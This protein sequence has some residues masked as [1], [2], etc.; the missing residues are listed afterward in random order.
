MGLPESA[1]LSAGLGVQCY[2]R[3]ATGLDWA[4]EVDPGSWT[5][6]MRQV[7][8]SSPRVLA[9]DNRSVPASAWPA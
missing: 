4:T 7:N 6:P 9:G 5:I 1:F 2:I 3:L 8:R